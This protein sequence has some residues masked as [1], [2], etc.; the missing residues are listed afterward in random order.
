[1]RVQQERAAAGA[2]LDDFNATYAAALQVDDGREAVVQA[3]ANNHGRRLCQ[4][5]TRPA[6][7]VEKRFVR[8]D[9][10]ARGHVAERDA[11]D[12]LTSV[13]WRGRRISVVLPTYNERESIRAAILDFAALDL[14]DEILVINN[15]AAAGTS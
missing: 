14:V 3:Q 4:P 12:S 13:S 9:C 11:H 1:V 8:G 10:L 6:R 5:E 15:N 2:A 7:G